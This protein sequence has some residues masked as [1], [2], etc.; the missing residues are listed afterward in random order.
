MSPGA[1]MEQGRFN[2]AG[3][4]A[5]S[6]PD[7]LSSALLEEH[8]RASYDAS[9]QERVNG[10]VQC[11]IV[12]RCRKEEDGSRVIRGFSYNRQT[13]TGHLVY[14]VL[15]PEE[16]DVAISDWIRDD[17]AE[18]GGG[19]TYYATREEGIKLLKELEFKDF[20]DGEIFPGD[21]DFVDAALTAAEFYNGNHPPETN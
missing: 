11:R 21:G 19:C 5:A 18:D 4:P 1:Q 9:T 7:A 20:A 17:S 8:L 13:G 2:H 16:T 10:R 15:G 12:S 3:K 14:H 6:G